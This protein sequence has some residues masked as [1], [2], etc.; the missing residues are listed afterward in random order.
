VEFVGSERLHG[1]RG[2]EGRNVN[3]IAES[4]H[5]GTDSSGRLIGRKAAACQQTFH[6]LLHR[7]LHVSLPK[8]SHFRP[9]FTQSSLLFVIL[10]GFISRGT[11]ECGR[12]TVGHRTIH[13]PGT[14]RGNSTMSTLQN[15]KDQADWEMEIHGTP[16]ACS[17]IPGQTA[18][19]VYRLAPTLSETR[20]EHL[21]NR[22]WRRFGRTLFRPECQACAACQSLRVNVLEFSPTRS[23]RRTASQIARSR[24]IVLE[25]QKPSV[26]REHILLYNRYHSDM[27]S[28]RQWPF[29]QINRDDYAE[30][31][32]DGDFDF[33]REF[34]YREHG[35]LIALG[36]VDVT[37]NTLSSVYFFHDP[38]LRSLGLGTWS[39][40]QEIA[41]AR[42][43]ARQWLHMGFYIRE[44]QSMNYK[45]RFSPHQI[46]QGRAADEEEPVWKTMEDGI[47]ED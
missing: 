42:E 17:Y 8:R 21:L 40:L 32:L 14:A 43:H 31:F 6:A 3:A 7:L 11:P 35:R 23:Q 33:A 13:S 5:D 10:H 44:C 9:E 45:N 22:G 36:L 2:E 25:V 47:P 24:Q 15:S 4:I 19:M 1:E 30:S 38:D 16:E 37:P 46:L 20:Y 28:R 18:R 39:V 34:Q 12:Q 27:H 41:F 26:T 29:R